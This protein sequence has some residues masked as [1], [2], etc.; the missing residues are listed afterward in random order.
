MRAALHTSGRAVLFVAASIGAGFAVMAFSR[1]H[2]LRLFGTLM[3]A[4]MALSCLA[5]LSLM[6][7]LVMRT[8][9][10][11]VFG[12]TDDAEPARERAHAV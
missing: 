9:P 4:A 2:G 12:T 6:P 7:V 5:A 1:F 3:P 11:F 10:V 8:R